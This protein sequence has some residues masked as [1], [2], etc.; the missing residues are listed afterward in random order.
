MGVHT[1]EKIK[2]FNTPEAELL[3]GKLFGMIVSMEGIPELTRGQ[4]N[5]QG[6]K[7]EFDY[8]GG[9]N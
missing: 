9:D 6:W 1:K 3:L 8:L 5:S 7:S 4:W 2:V